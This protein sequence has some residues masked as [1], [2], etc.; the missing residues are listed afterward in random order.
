[1]RALLPLLCFTPLAAGARVLVAAGVEEV[2]KGLFDIDIQ[3]IG[4]PGAHCDVLVME[5]S[6][7][8]EA[9]VAGQPAALVLLERRRSA[10]EALLAGPRLLRGAPPRRLPPGYEVAWEFLVE[11]SLE[12]PRHLVRPGFASEIPAKHG[13]PLRRALK[14][15]GLF[16]F[17]PRDR[18]LVLTRAGAG[19]LV[20][21]L[22]AQALGDGV[23]RSAVRRIYV[24]D[25][26]VLAVT[27][28]HRGATLYLRIPFS[29]RA[30]E[31][32]RRGHDLALRIRGLGFSLAPQP[33]V[34][35]AGGLSPFHLE[36]GLP[37]CPY[38]GGG[39]EQATASALAAL[40]PIHTA[41]TRVEMDTNLFERVVGSR[42]KRIGACIDDA[43]SLDNV[44]R[45]LRQGLLGKTVL[46]SYCH[47]DFKLGNCLFDEK[48]RVSGIVDW[49]MGSVEDLT[50][51]DLINLHGKLIQER[52][53]AT[54]A[55]A[56]R[57]CGGRVFGDAY[58]NYF[59]A[60][61]TS[62][63]EPP[64]ALLLWWVDRVYMQYQY[65]SG[66]GVWSRRHVQPLL[67]AFATGP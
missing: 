30:L 56:A 7:A 28:A 66:D 64:E 34:F 50:L 16:Y 19:D 12:R 37:G 51:L 11:P 10:A 9:A 17:L 29:E 18:A 54:L 1:M 6:G 62:P 59:R 33:L 4:T 40:L 36:S 65:G 23:A 63:V 41:G 55:E 48:R 25:N 27:I 46:L 35:N 13:S 61:A 31:R 21:S 49:D 22:I 2:G 53:G 38:A 44:G 15:G 20:R 57:D 39:D 52:T 8:C 24:S 45:R 32:L 47:G 58:R 42:L 26:D 43:G 67:R 5:A 14:R 60:T 3:S